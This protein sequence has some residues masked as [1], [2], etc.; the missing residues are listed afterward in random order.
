MEILKYPI[1]SFTLKW[2]ED[3]DQDSNWLR[4]GDKIPE[5]GRCNN[6]T[7]FYKMFKTDQNEEQL[8]EIMEDFIQRYF[9]NKPNIHNPIITNKHWE[10]KGREAWVLTWFSHETFDVGQTDEEALAS[11]EAFVAEKE[12]LIHEEWENDTPMTISLMGA[13]DRYR[14]RSGNED[15]HEVP[16]RCEYCK[17]DG[18]LRIA[19]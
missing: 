5:P 11:F 1:Y 10:F 9:P 8:E 18:L 12:L 19:H 4:E 17:R 7:H 14:W 16:C 15:Y 13:D 3:G 6:S 2:T